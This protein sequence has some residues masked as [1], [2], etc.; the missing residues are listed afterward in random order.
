VNAYRMQAWD[1][2]DYVDTTCERVEHA[3]I[4]LRR[5]ARAIGVIA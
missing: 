4:D 3:L 5:T 1:E 2:H